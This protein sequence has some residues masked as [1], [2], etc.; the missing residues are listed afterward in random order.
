M[1]N[2]IFYL[3]IIIIILFNSLSIL[4]K[5]DNSIKETLKKK[6]FIEYSVIISLLLLLFIVKTNANKFSINILL[7]II[8][9][10]Q[11]GCGLAKTF[12]PP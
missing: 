9:L 6:V 5:T 3:L 8:F 11:L 7:F 12:G 10:L 1:I 2:I 4:S